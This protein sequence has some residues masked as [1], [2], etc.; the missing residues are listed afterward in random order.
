MPAF[1]RPGEDVIGRCRLLAKATEDPG[2]ITRTFL[3]KPMHQV[4]S[5]LRGWMEQAGMS[6]SIDHAGNIRG[7][8]PSSRPSAPGLFMGSHLD[9]VPHAGAFDGILDR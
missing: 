8:Y 6:V 2:F 4:H 5:H 3:S 1:D 7:F 9:T